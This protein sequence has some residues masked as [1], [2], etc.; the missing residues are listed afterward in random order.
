MQ[1]WVGELYVILKKNNNTTTPPQKTTNQN[2]KNEQIQA[3]NVLRLWFQVYQ[4]CV[5][6]DSIA[7]CG[8]VP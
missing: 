1:E 3:R 2:L 7:F 5:R 4:S 6:V 8:I